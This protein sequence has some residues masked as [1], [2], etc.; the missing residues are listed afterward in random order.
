[1]T[2]LDTKSLFVYIFSI[3]VFTIPSLPRK[4]AKIGKF[5]KIPMVRL[6]SRQ[7]FSKNLQMSLKN[8]PAIQNKQISVDLGRN[9]GP[10]YKK[11]PISPKPQPKSKFLKTYRVFKNGVDFAKLISRIFFLN[12]RNSKARTPLKQLMRSKEPSRIKVA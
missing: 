7:N 5:L 6:N 8:L 11:N 10:E 3:I 9:R 2:H 12:F 1:M 4:L